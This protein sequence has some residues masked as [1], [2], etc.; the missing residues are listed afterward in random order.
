[1]QLRYLFARA[2]AR[3]GMVFP[4]FFLLWV[5]FDRPFI[6]AERVFKCSSYPAPLPLS[7]DAARAP[8]EFRRGNVFV[9]MHLLVR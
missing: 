8:N 1:M 9:S 7:R 3:W 4:L 6:N 5:G 2:A